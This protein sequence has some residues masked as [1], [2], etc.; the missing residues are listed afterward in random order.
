MR[1]TTTRPGHRTCVIDSWSLEDVRATFVDGVLEVSVPVPAKPQ[2]T[3]RKVE[4]EGG[5]KA[6]KAA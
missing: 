1:P 3:V 5:E 4:I 2:A 6:A